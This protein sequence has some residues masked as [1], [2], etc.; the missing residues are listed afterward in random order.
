MNKKVK[1]ALAM[2]VIGLFCMGSATQDDGCQNTQ[3]QARLTAQEE[4]ESR[5]YYIP[6]NH[7]EY[8]N[9]NKRQ[10]LSDDPTEILWCTAYPTNPNCKPMTFA[11]K[12]KLTSGSK[13]PFPDDP[14]PDGMYGSSGEYRYG[15]T[16]A[17]NYVDFTGIETICTDQLMVW[18]KE[19]TNIAIED[20]DSTKK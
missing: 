13:R 11:I 3:Y 4:A 19:T 20:V 6:R 16:P 2:G 12:G 15:F 14:G 1:T 10:A 18:Q 5:R 7:M 9:Y 8:D 17:G